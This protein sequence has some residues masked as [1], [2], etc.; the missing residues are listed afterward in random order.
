MNIRNQ[1]GSIRSRLLIGLPLIALLMYFG[2][3]MAQS[4]DPCA[5]YPHKSVNVPLGTPTAKL[6]AGV[7]GEQ[8]Y[9]CSVTVAQTAATPGLTLSYGEVAAGTPC[10]TATPGDTLGVFGGIVG[11]GTVTH[12]GDYTLLGPVPAAAGTPVVDVCGLVA[13]GNGITGGSISYVQIKP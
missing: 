5:I 2:F 12:G 6:I 11:G 4:A 1:E 7:I 8:I 3:A 13:A 9:I 10:A